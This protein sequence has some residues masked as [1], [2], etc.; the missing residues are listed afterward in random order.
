M[1]SYPPCPSWI[2]HS[3]KNTGDLDSI[4]G[5]DRYL[6]ESLESGTQQESLHFGTAPNNY[7]LRESFVEIGSLTYGI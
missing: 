6:V 4:P 2:T 5:T 3:T 1:P 7:L